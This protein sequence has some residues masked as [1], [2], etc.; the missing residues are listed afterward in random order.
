MIK[1][2]GCLGSSSTTWN[3]NV[4]AHTVTHTHGIPHTLAHTHSTQEA[5]LTLAG[6]FDLR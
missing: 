1:I 6:Y 3:G 5:G 2:V 4:F